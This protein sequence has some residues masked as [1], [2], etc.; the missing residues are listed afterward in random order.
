MLQYEEWWKSPYPLKQINTVP[1]LR[2]FTAKPNGAGPASK[3]GDN[4]EHSSK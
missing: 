3:L 4:P 1:A 2:G